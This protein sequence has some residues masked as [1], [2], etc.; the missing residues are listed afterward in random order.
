MATEKVTIKVVI[1]DEAA[2]DY[3]LVVGLAVPMLDLE[4]E[5]TTYLKNLEE[6]GRLNGYYL[7][8][9]YTDPE[10]DVRVKCFIYKGD[11]Y[12]N[13]QL[14]YLRGVCLSEDWSEE[15]EDCGQIRFWLKTSINPPDTIDWVWD[16][17]IKEELARRMQEDEDGEERYSMVKELLKNY[18]LNKAKTSVGID[19]KEIQELKE[20][21]DFLDLCISK[22]DGEAYGLIKEHYVNGRSLTFVGKMFGYS[23]TGARYKR[24]R[25][26]TILE[27]L[28][29]EKYPR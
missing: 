5:C 16:L 2:F 8:A 3:E 14:W 28:F 19:S 9:D 12:K 20:Q 17:R 6:A 22:L 25:A 27:I 29:N 7:K 15:L 24:D 13:E 23:K 1:T 11:I 21:M 4:A 26:I 10:T 18:K